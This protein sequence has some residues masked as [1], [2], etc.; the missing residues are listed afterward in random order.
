M[1]TRIWILLILLGVGAAPHPALRAQATSAADLRGR[2]EEAERR[3]DSAQQQVPVLER[4]IQDRQ[5]LKATY[6]IYYKL[7]QPE[8][9]RFKKAYDN[10]VF[11]L[12]RVVAQDATDRDRQIAADKRRVNPRRHDVKSR[13]GGWL[14]VFPD[15]YA[16]GA[17]GSQYLAAE[18][19][20]ENQRGIYYG[21]KDRLN[22]EIRTAFGI[23]VG[24]LTP[25]RD[26]DSLEALAKEQ[27]SVLAS[28]TQELKRLSDT[29]LPALRAEIANLQSELREAERRER[30]QAEAPPPAPQGQVV[31]YE[32][33]MST[34][35]QQHFQRLFQSASQ[36]GLRVT[37]SNMF[38]S[39]MRL[40]IAP[41]TRRAE[42][43]P[44]NATMGV[45]AVAS[46][47]SRA[48]E[49]GTFGI[50]ATLVFAATTLGSDGRING[51]Y[52]SRF[53]A[54]GTGAAKDQTSNGEVDLPWRAVPDG[55]AA[56]KSEGVPLPAAFL[57][58]F[59]KGSGDPP[60]FRLQCVG[61]Q[62]DP[63]AAP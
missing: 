33:P 26:Y 23:G 41:R 63:T 16:Y 48:N 10:Y 9:E 38:F 55:E 29:D 36:D 17:Y 6:Q 57:V 31:V 20:L 32:G 11:Y 62:L 35:M 56:F 5:K 50:S 1:N 3:L 27:E 45:G 15:W 46:D 42:A 8:K 47:P 12:E 18:E 43:D 49:S 22:E 21:I 58:Y 44:V 39:P 24:E 34:E 53:E 54:H 2:L 61:T 59:G 13:W 7:L 14:G 19:E 52:R 4:R 60:M 25:P 37:Q 28:L 30:E 40:R 51:T